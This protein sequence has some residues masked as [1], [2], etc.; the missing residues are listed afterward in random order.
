MAR[1]L[2]WGNVLYA[3]VTAGALTVKASASG[4]FRSGNSQLSL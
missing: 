2:P 1:E 4:S 3:A